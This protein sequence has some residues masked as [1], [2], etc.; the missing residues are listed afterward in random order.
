MAPEDRRSR[1]RPPGAAATRERT[2]RGGDRHTR[3]EGRRTEHT[4]SPAR[5]RD[6]ES[7]PQE[8]TRTGRKHRR[9]PRGY[10]QRDEHEEDQETTMPAAPQPRDSRNER[11]HQR[12]TRSRHAQSH[13]R[14][15]PLLLRER[16]GRASRNGNRRRPPPHRGG[17]KKSR[18]CRCQ[19]SC[20]ACL[21]AEEDGGPG[22]SRGRERPV[23]RPLETW[24]AAKL[25]P[26]RWRSLLWRRQNLCW[27]RKIRGWLSRGDWGGVPTVRAALRL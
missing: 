4:G 19:K 12:Q 7:R 22:M 13:R 9:L 15:A 10:G 1:E 26:A 23:W 2:P 27:F 11:Q 24:K 6:Q 20:F 18:M 8:E 3:P 17:R 14:R 5:S 21:G 25:S 16:R